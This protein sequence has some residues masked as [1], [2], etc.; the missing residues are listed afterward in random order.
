VLV[1]TLNP[2]Q[3]I[4]IQG[5]GVPRQFGLSQQSGNV[6]TAVLNELTGS[7]ARMCIGSWF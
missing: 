5:S 7:R 6:S 3:S 1:E 2:A 4:I